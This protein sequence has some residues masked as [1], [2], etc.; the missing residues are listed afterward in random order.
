MIFAGTVVTKAIGI[1]VYKTVLNVF[2]NI[3]TGYLVIPSNSFAIARK[4]FLGLD[5][6]KLAKKRYM[7][8]QNTNAIHTPKRPKSIF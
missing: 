2:P 1:T 8:Y 3:S 7:P 6:V 4:P 5:I